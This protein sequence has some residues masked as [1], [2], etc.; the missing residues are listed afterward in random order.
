MAEVTWA[1]RYEKTVDN[2]YRDFNMGGDRDY[3]ICN[4]FC[5][6]D[7]TELKEENYVKGISAT[8]SN[9]TLHINPIVN[10]EPA[11][12][13]LKAVGVH[14]GETTKRVKEEEKVYII[15]GFGN[16]GS[17]DRYELLDIFFRSPSKAVIS[18]KRYQMEV[19][20]VFS[21]FNDKYLVVCV[22]IEVSP[23]NKTDDP[24]R[25]NLFEILMAISKDFPTKGKTYSVQDSPN[26]DPRVFLPVNTGDNSSF[27][28]WIDK[29]SDNRVMYIQFKSPISVPYK[30]FEVFANTLL[31]GVNN[32]KQKTTQPPQEEYAGLE[33][34]Y[35]INEPNRKITTVQKC[36]EKTVPYLQELVNFNKKEIK[37]KQKTKEPEKC[38]NNTLLFII[39]FIVFLLLTGFGIF[40]F[41]ITKKK[42]KK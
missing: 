2:K 11:Q 8:S 7:I 18:G 25:K 26:W 10:T 24:L 35:N 17:R 12:K 42:L 29:A 28:T 21:S 23:T 19:C 20:L 40:Y 39:L 14:S 5:N 36:E 34:Y 31:G 9:N 4:I 38:K 1:S 22:P 41:F 27:F 15:Y 16:Y 6:F 32:A 13:G 30:F 33:I 3:P 37:E